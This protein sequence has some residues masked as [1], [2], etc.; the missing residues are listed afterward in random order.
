MADAELHSCRPSGAGTNGKAVPVAERRSLLAVT[1]IPL[2][3]VRNGLSLR[4]VHLLAELASDWEITLIAPSSAGHETAGYPAGI[5]RILPL[6]LASRSM[7]SPSPADL[8]S[9]R[10]AA[11]TAI[12][13]LGPTAALLWPGADALLAGGTLALPTV[14]DRVD[15]MSLA[16]WREVAKAASSRQRMRMLRETAAY[17]RYERR[18]VRAAAATVV[19]GEDDARV[20]RRL[21]PGRVVEV[22]PNG[23]VLGA[24]PTPAEESGTPLVVFSGTMAYGPNIEAARYFAKEVWASVRSRVPDARFVIAGRM[25]TAEI[26]ALDGRG[27]IEVWPDVADM[28]AVLRSAW[29]AV[30]PMRSGTGIKNKV[31]E[32]WAAGTPVVLTR[33]AANGLHLDA[34]AARLVADDAEPLAA[35]VVALLQDAAERHRLGLAAYRLAARHS[36]REAAAR[37]DSLLNGVQ[38]EARARPLTSR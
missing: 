19:V 13:E 11:E 37:I 35:R 24:V 4:I 7:L 36:W 28:G 34:D 18:I 5:E 32:A 3:D 20:L 15:C 10:A 29:V 2:A 25:P 33:M 17:A 38:V 30:A 12:R 27:G 26:L 8:A 9:L 14:I 31:L 23:V 16:A 6:S 21:A 22:V 1:T